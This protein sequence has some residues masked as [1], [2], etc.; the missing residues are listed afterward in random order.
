MTYKILMNCLIC[1]EEVEIEWHA[2]GP[3]ICDKC[4]QAVMH[5]RNELDKKEEK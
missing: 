1:G 2:K 5:I 3:K 4:R